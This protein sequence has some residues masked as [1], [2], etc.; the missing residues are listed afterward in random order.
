MTQQ[1][2][3]VCLSVCVV[4]FRA[5]SSNYSPASYRRMRKHLAVV[6]WAHICVLW[7]TEL[8][9]FLHTADN[10]VYCSIILRACDK[11][12][13]SSKHV[14]DPHVVQ[15]INLLL[16]LRFMSPHI[17]TCVSFSWRWQ[18]LY[19][20]SKDLLWRCGK[21][22]NINFKFLLWEVTKQAEKGCS[23]AACSSGLLKRVD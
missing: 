5:S 13:V 9:S 8:W 3:S 10:A 22:Y 23:D 2:L 20:L 14:R 17:N 4:I 18:S 11:R 19:G 15:T 6:C 16:S 12:E 1:V 21:C 7:H